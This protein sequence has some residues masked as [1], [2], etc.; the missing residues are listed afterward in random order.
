MRAKV[1]TPFVHRGAAVMPGTVIEMTKEEFDSV[2]FHVAPVAPAEPVKKVE[3][4]QP[5]PV[6]PAVVEK[7]V[8][9]KKAPVKP[10]EKKV[11]KKTAKATK[12]K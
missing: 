1:L 8:I 6:K 9:E 3:T 7:K 11:V 12:R 4:I 2:I 10:V 5:E